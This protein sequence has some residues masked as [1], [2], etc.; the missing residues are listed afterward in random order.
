[1]DDLALTSFRDLRKEGF[2]DG[3][4]ACLGVK[5]DCRHP[6]F[7]VPANF[8]EPAWNGSAYCDVHDP[9]TVAFTK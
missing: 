5:G 8:G 2:D 3:G 4:Y 1:M 6:A 9:R 7:I